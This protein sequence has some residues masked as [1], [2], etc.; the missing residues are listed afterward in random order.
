[1]NTKIFKD[2]I[3]EVLSQKSQE[4]ISEGMIVTVNKL[5]SDTIRVPE[6]DYI[7]ARVHSNKCTLI[8]TTEAHGQQVFEVFKPTLAGFFNPEVHRRTKEA[9]S[10]GIISEH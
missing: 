2:R 4:T 7:I 6:G 5:V 8:P 3:D 9:P 1:M 10:D